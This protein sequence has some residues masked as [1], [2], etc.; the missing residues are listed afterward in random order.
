MWLFSNKKLF[1]GN[2][3]ET[4]WHMANCLLVKRMTPDCMELHC[5]PGCS[6]LEMQQQK[7]V[8]VTNKI[9][10]L[11]VKISKDSK[12]LKLYVPFDCVSYWQVWINWLFMISC[13]LYLIVINS[14]YFIHLLIP[15]WT[16]IENLL[17]FRHYS[18]TGNAVVN[19][20]DKDLP[21][22]TV[23]TFHSKNNTVMPPT[24]GRVR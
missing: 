23:D 19:E 17:H 1:E 10:V 14:L 2:S 18:G 22:M 21:F 8:R 11:M 9:L 13:K 12:K 15:S 24:Q 3:P 5:D 7:E 20:R 6:N 4:S 16:Y